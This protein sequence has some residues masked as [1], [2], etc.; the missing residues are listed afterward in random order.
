MKRR[1]TFSY[2]LWWSSIGLVSMADISTLALQ[3]LRGVSVYSV[4]SLPQAAAVMT[5]AAGRP[6]LF[7]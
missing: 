4:A 7:M 1:E 3:Q 6:C 5:I 2:N